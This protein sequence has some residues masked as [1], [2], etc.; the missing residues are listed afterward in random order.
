MINLIRKSFT[1]S[2]SHFLFALDDGADHFQVRSERLWWFSASLSAMIDY[3]VRVWISILFELAS[4]VV[5]NCIIWVKLLK[6]SYTRWFPHGHLT[7]SPVT[8]FVNKEIRTKETS[9]TLHHHQIRQ[10]YFAAPLLGL[11]LFLSRPHWQAHLVFQDSL[12][13]KRHPVA[14]GPIAKRRK[15]GK[16]SEAFR[17]LLLTPTSIRHCKFR[18]R[19]AYLQ[20]NVNNACYC[21]VG[22]L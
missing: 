3:L 12:N 18:H 13:I 21:F 5:V 19:A 8:T 9:F 7:P 2:D 16:N 20:Q 14:L 1:S 22:S 4:S 10:D 11:Q 6:F 17:K 15:L